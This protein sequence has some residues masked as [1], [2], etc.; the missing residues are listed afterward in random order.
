MTKPWPNGM[1]LSSA[2]PTAAGVPDS[3]TGITRSAS[4][5]NSRASWRPISTRAC[6]DAAA[7]DGGVGAGEVDVLEHAAL[8]RGLGEAVGAQAVLVDRRSARRARPRGRRWRRSVARAASSEATTQPRSSRPR[9]SGRMPCGSRAAYSVSS[10]IQTNE[11]A[12]RSSGSTSSARCSSEVSGWCGEQRGD[13]RRCRWWSVSSVARVELE[14][15]AEAG[16]VGD[17]LLELVGVDQVAVVAERDRAVVGRAGT[18]AGRSARCW[19]R[20]WSSARGRSRGGP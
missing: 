20:W 10:F 9:T 3:G 7:G 19:R 11:K 5:G 17:H 12:P 15:A 1:P 8:G 4:T 13:Q 6:V 2:Y 18:S 14:L 16:Q